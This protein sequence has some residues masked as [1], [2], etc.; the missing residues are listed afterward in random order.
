MP[1]YLDYLLIRLITVEC[2]YFFQV[3]KKLKMGFICV[4]KQL[5]R[6]IRL[7][8]GGISFKSANS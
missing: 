8:Q 3:F 4:Q 2:Y 6:D 7:I 1:C 5:L